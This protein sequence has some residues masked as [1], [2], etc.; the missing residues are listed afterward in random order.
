M[1]RFS[2]G[3]STNFNVISFQNALTTARNSEL[4]ATINYIN[5]IAECDRVQ[6]IQ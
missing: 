2:V 4:N 6:K 5:A 3:M 1:T